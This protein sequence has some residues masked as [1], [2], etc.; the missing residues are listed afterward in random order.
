MYIE[1]KSFGMRVLK[2]FIYGTERRY[3]IHEDILGAA[4]FGGFVAVNGDDDGVEYYKLVRIPIEEVERT[5]SV[6]SVEKKIEEIEDAV[7]SLLATTE[8]KK[9]ALTKLKIERDALHQPAAS[10]KSPQVSA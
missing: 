8:E 5:V 9:K 6:A 1:V 3:S 2:T 4:D 7:I 10:E